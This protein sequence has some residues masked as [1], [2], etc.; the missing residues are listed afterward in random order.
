MLH[1]CKAEFFKHIQLY[2]KKNFKK[3]NSKIKNR[4][5]KLL[6]GADLEIRNRTS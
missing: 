6:S 1:K 3:Q 5:I 4:K 2:D